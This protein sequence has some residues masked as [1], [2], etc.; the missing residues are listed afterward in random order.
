[1]V[2]SSLAPLHFG[3]LKEIARI[4]PD[5]ALANMGQVAKNLVAF[6][7][8]DSFLEAHDRYFDPTYSTYRYVNT[9]LGPH[10]Q[11]TSCHPHP[12]RLLAIA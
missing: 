5:V 6:N 1:M 12:H 3:I 2:I 7:I 9:P 4:N 10:L 8:I 11:C